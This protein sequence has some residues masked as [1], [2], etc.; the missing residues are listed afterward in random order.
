MKLSNLFM[1]ALLAGT[2]GVFGCDSDPQTGNGGSGG[3]GTAGTGGD[4]T[5]GTGGGTAGSGGTGGT[6]APD[7]SCDAICSGPCVFFTFD[8]S[9]S[10]CQSDCESAPDGNLGTDNCGPEMAAWLE[11]AKDHDCSDNPVDA[12]LDCP[13]EFSNWDTCNI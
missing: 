7:T 1:I 4:G 9:S 8:P 11:C 5:A 6:T 13:I 12:A 3:D 2:L 10:T